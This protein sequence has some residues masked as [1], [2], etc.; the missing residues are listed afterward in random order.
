[1]LAEQAGLHSRTLAEAGRA[2]CALRG[3]RPHRFRQSGMDVAAEVADLEKSVRC[4]ACTGS[5]IL[6][7]S[8]PEVFR[9]GLTPHSDLLVRRDAGSDVRDGAGNAG[10]RRGHPAAGRWHVRLVDPS[11][12]CGRVLAEAE[13]K[14]AGSRL[15]GGAPR[16]R[17]TSSEEAWIEVVDDPGAAG[18]QRQGAPDPAGAALGGCRAACR[19]CARRASRRSRPR[20]TGRRSAA[21][22]WERCRRDWEAAGDYGRAAVRAGLPDA[23]AWAGVPR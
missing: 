6:A 1:M 7:L 21:V 18:S 11:R 9:P 16:S 15:R 10:T 19:A 8:P 20:R 12:P 5:S 17:R 2:S 14:V 4:P 22:A 3:G 23:S 13:F